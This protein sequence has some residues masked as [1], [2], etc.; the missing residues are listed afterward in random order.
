MNYYAVHR[1]SNPNDELK[2][3]KYIKKIKRGGKWRYFYDQ[4]DLINFENNAKTTSIDDKGITTDTEYKKT[5]KLF[6]G[7]TKV[8]F[9]SG[10][11]TTNRVTYR[12]GKIDR[13]IA[14]GERKVYETFYKPGNLFSKKVNELKKGTKDSIRGVGELWNTITPKVSFIKEPGKRKRMRI[15]WH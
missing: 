4:E 3:W 13:A 8:S 12:Q 14:K 6:G 11:V 2:H 1:S 10:G 5:N 15:G 9:S 7:K